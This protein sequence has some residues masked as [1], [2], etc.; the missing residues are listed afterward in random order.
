MTSV[1]GPS[2]GQ[3]GRRLAGALRTKQQ[4][5]RSIYIGIDIYVYICTI[6]RCIYMYTYTSAGILMFI[7]VSADNFSVVSG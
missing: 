3:A 5:L 6:Y 4:L 7:H 2:A 1:A